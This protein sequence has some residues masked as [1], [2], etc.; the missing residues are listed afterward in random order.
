MLKPKSP[1]IAA[2]ESRGRPSRHEVAPQDPLASVQTSRTFASDISFAQYDRCADDTRSATP[3]YTLQAAHRTGH[4]RS[5]PAIPVP[6]A[7]GFFVSALRNQPVMPKAGLICFTSASSIYSEFFARKPQSH[8][9]EAKIQTEM[10]K[11]NSR[12]LVVGLSA[13]PTLISP[14]MSDP[15]RVFE[16]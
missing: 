16:S 14:P 11:S 4:I 7:L 10:E 13:P 9:A 1:E 15:E 8:K 12:Y 3:K 6:S 2:V 5:L